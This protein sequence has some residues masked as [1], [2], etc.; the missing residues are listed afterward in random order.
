LKKKTRGGFCKFE[1]TFDTCIYFDS[2]KI[3]KIFWKECYAS[4]VGTWVVLTQEVHPIAYFSEKLKGNNL[5]YS[6]NDKELF[7]LVMS[8]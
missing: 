5:N 6:T 7:A 2:S 1:K 8:L 4:N 3:F